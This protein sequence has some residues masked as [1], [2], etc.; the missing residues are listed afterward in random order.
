MSDALARDDVVVKN[1]GAEKI[2]TLFDRGFGLL[3]GM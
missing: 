3:F 1:L 2:D